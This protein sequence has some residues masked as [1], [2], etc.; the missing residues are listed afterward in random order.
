MLPFGANHRIVQVHP[1][2]WCNLSCLHCY[3]SSGP[4]QTAKLPHDILCAAIQDAA[5]EGYTWVSVSGGEPLMYGGLLQLLDAARS[6][7]MGTSMVSN[8]ILLDARRIDGLSTRLDLLE[9]SI[10]GRPELHDGIRGSQGAFRRMAGRLPHLRE[11]GVPFGF[12]LTLSDESADDLLW[13]LDF[14]LEQ[15]ARA[16]K[17]H[18]LGETGRAVVYLR[19]RTPTSRALATWG[20]VQHLAKAYED[21]IAITTD[22]SPITTIRDLVPELLS[23]EDPAHWLLSQAVSPLVI[24]D[25]GTVVPLAYGF[26]REHALGSMRKIRLGE[27]AR[28]WL[29]NPHG[30]EQLRSLCRR[31]YAQVLAEGTEVLT[32]YREVMR[33]AM[34]APPFLVPEA[35]PIEAREL[36]TPHELAPPQAIQPLG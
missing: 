24:E 12:V 18:G 34:A 14:A 25:D 13:V 2:R 5:A 20:A 31:T 35:A 6:A 21:R 1:S 4:Y 36:A 27:L 9:I 30:Y 7:G 32:W 3:S 26:P 22:L 8:G 19:G 15:G 11:A 10:E 33:H 16:L 17:I 23:Q 28:R 29:A